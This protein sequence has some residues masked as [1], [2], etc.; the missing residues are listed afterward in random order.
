MFPYKLQTQ[1]LVLEVSREKWLICSNEMLWWMWNYF[2]KV[3]HLLWRMSPLVL[4]FGWDLCLHRKRNFLRTSFSNFL[5][6]LYNW[7]TGWTC[8][9]NC[10]L[11]N[12]VTKT[13]S[14]LRIFIFRKNGFNICHHFLVVPFWKS[15]VHFGIP[16]S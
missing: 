12:K 10:V 14:W 7:E 5:E 2:V 9:W 11:L 3:F 4:Y 13:N 15:S 16:Y 8:R 1:Q 6:F